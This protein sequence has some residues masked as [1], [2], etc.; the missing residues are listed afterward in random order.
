M[1]AVS[2]NTTGKINVLTSI[3]P[4][5]LSC[6]A[7]EALTLACPCRLDATTG[8]AYRT[9]ANDGTTANRRCYGIA[10]HAAAAGE[11]VTL[12]REVLTDSFDVS[13]LDF[14][15]R[16]Y[17][18]DTIGE[19]ADAAGTA[20]IILGQVVPKFATNIGTT[21]DKVLHIQVRD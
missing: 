2:L 12:Y 21:A 17:A 7:G 8:K 6:V 13:A 5:Q 1:A 19:V 9:D 20:S 3:S 15:A 4:V 11:A 14:G 18:S 16:V 10:S